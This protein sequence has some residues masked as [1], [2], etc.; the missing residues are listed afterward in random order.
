MNERAGHRHR[1]DLDPLLA[2]LSPLH[3]GDEAPAL[4]RDAVGEE[5]ESLAVGVG[6]HLVLEALGL[7]FEVEVQA[8]PAR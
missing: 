7:A 2:D 6:A 1:S 4:A 3:D 5:L 8:R